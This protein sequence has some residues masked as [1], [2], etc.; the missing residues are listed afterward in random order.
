MNCPLSSGMRKRGAND[1]QCVDIATFRAEPFDTVLIIGRT[2]GMVED[3]PHLQRFLEDVRGLV[4]SDGQILLNSLDVRCTNNA[5]DLA[6]QEANRQAGCYFGELRLRFE[7]RGQKGSTFGWLY[8][9]PET[10]AHQAHRSG[11]LYETVMQQED[12]NY[13]ARLTPSECVP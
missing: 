9:E 1:V 2:I 10:L 7:Y 11:W 6:Y 4:K 8:V 3:L 5:T 12:G 13:L